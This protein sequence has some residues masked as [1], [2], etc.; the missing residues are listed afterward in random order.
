MIW[1]LQKNEMI[2]IFLQNMR[3]G[4]SLIARVWRLAPRFVWSIL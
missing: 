3:Y 2:E 1:K 4:K